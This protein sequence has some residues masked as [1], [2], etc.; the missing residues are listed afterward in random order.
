MGV[1][2]ELGVGELL[3]VRKG[4]SEGV[5]E[6]AVDQVGEGQRQSR[7]GVGLMMII[8]GSWANATRS[9]VPPGWSEAPGTGA[10]A[11]ARVDR[12]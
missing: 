1:G 4:S 8:C 7:V 12:Q 2:E 11:W 5:A 10:A 6:V 3:A 9:M